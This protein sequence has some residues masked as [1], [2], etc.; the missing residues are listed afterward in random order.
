[1]Q[2]FV[3]R[4]YIKNRQRL[5]RRLQT[6]GFLIL[7]LSF[8]LAIL[9][10]GIFGGSTAPPP[11]SGVITTTN[12]VSG[13]LRAT[14][15]V[16]ASG[17]ISGTGAV[18]QPVSQ[19][20]TLQLITYYIGLLLGFFLLTSGQWMSR[21]WKAEPHRLLVE[22]LTDFNNKYTFYNYLPLTQ[23]TAVD[24]LIMGPGGFIVIQLQQETG[25]IVCRNDRWRR[26]TGFIERL[27]SIGAPPL[28][29]PSLVLDLQI[30]QVKK[31]LTAQAITAPQV[32]GAVVFSNPRAQIDIQD[33]RYP[34]FEHVFL[35]RFVR[36]KLAV[37]EGDV[38]KSEAAKPEADGTPRRSLNMAE[39]QKAGNVILATMAE[40]EEVGK[41]VKTAPGKPGARPTPGKPAARPTPGGL[42]SATTRQ[43]IVAAARERAAARDREKAKK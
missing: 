16:T 23:R 33:C 26:R 9:P 4:A 31:L 37:N 27:G 30:E 17:A 34:V 22:Q 13:T 41:E 19:I 18:A 3:N 39:R 35:N 15:T 24:H 12:V 25:K 38:P 28:G 20:S 2:T 6:F 10:G 29:N 5:G 8:V 14:S 42:N 36:E 43:S 11:A 1:M 21:K 7:G 32:Y 40:V